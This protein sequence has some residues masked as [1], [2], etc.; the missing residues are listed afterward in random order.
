MGATTRRK[1]VQNLRMDDD[2]EMER[3]D[4]FQD[5]MRKECMDKITVPKISNHDTGEGIE[6][7][8]ASISTTHRI[9]NTPKN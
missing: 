5:R 3:M 6:F 8:K 1:Q 4:K 9:T 7:Q 2:T